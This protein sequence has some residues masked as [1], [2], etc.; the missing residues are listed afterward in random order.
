MSAAK[1]Q[2][3]HEKTTFDKSWKEVLKR[4]WAHYLKR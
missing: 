2:E 1:G 3:S 4:K